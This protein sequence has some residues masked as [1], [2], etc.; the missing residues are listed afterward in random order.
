MRVVRTVAALRGQ[1]RASELRHFA[2]H[3]GERRRDVI[4][5][6]GNVA[7]LARANGQVQAHRLEPGRGLQQLRWDVGIAQL[8]A[9]GVP[10][11]A[12]HFRHR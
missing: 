4:A 5:C 2:A 1:I 6:A 12:A 11:D 8:D 9:A 3:A 7:D 10:I